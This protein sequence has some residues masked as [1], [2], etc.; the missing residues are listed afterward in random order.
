MGESLFQDHSGV[1]VSSLTTWAGREGIRRN[2]DDLP[3]RHLA[4]ARSGASSM[5]HA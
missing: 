3:P 1:L 2:F 4:D 5:S